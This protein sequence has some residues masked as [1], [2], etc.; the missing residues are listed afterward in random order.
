MPKHPQFTPCLICKNKYDITQNIICP[1]CLDEPSDD[2]DERLL[3]DR[4]KE[5]FDN[6][7][8]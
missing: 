8:E 2:I 4:L 6:E 7:T 1:Y 5:G 3:E